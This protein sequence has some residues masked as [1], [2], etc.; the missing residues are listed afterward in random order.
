[1]RRQLCDMKFRIFTVFF[2][3]LAI[4]LVSC[5]PQTPVAT[6]NAKAA[7]VSEGTQSSPVYVETPVVS[8]DRGAFRIILHYAKNGAPVR[9]QNIYLAEM[10]PLQGGMEGAFVPALDTSSAPRD[11]SSASGEVVVSM[12]PPGKYAL[13]LLTP[14][15][16]VLIID[17]DTNHEVTFDIAG[18]KITDLGDLNVVLDQDMLEPSTGG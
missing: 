11:E 2:I 5:R 17:S 16:A 3:P 10:L 6:S 9:G 13:S 7:S 4:F 8:S 15:G 12:V 18:G 1:L 14:M